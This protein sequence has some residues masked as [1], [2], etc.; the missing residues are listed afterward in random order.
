MKTKDGVF[1]KFQEFKAKVENLKGR[2]IKILRS[3][4]GGE[5]TSKEPVAYCKEVGI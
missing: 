2:K 1:K 5:Y 3:D 4:K